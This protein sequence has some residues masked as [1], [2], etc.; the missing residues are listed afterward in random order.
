MA[1]M[2]ERYGTQCVYYAHVS[3][4]EMHL[5]PEL[6]LKTHEGMAAFRGIAHDTALLVKE[7]GG[8][9]SGEHG[10][11]RL[12]APFLPLMLGDE[13]YALLQK[14][15]YA[16]DPDGI[17]NPGKIVDTKPFD[18]DLR[19]GPEKLHEERKTYFHWD[20]DFGLLRAAE[21]CNGAGSCRKSPGRGTMCPSYMATQDEKDTT[22]ARAN[23]FRTALMSVDPAQEFDSDELYNILDLCLSCKGCKAECPA[24]VDMAR[25]KAEFLQQR[26]DARGVPLRARMFGEFAGL[27]GLARFTPGL[28]NWT[29]RQGFVKRALGVHPKRRVPD[30]AAQTF[31]VWA[32]ARKPLGDGRLGEVVVFND[33]FTHYNDPH[34]GIAAVEFL[35]LAGYKVHV[36]EG[37]DSG[38]THLSKGLLRRARAIL[39]EAVEALHPWV[40]RGVCV[41]GL[42][43][44]AILTFRD[45]APDLVEGEALRAKARAVGQR[46]LLFEEFV[47]REAG[48]GKLG[49][50]KFKDEPRKLLVHGHCHQKALVGMEPTRKMFAL[51]P[52]TQVTVIPSGCCGMAGSFG[53][54]AEHYDLSMKV[55]ELVLFPAVRQAAPDVV[56]IAPGTSC[57]HQLH[58]GTGAKSLHPAEL[59]R[60]ALA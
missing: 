8:S 1:E 46:A 47:S 55:G 3:V 9:L 58:D 33:A 18:T 24:N 10:D 19:V 45:E 15:K 38:R 14:L 41:V 37:I 20:G 32:K 51:L 31:G 34:V 39:T 13:V 29:L 40:E 21:K 52:Q 5:R 12:R 26:Y 42:E 54:E 4:G 6:N 44:S 28:A 16:F 57:R 43:P 22:R 7:F 53:Y 11:G 30:I 36:T 35:E 60:K 48:A 25:M 56:V 17:L 27:T 59:M 49:H 23:M 2:M 50:L